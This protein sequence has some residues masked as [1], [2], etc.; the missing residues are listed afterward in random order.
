MKKVLI[1]VT[2]LTSGQY[3]IR[4]NLIEEYF[5]LIQEYFKSKIHHKYVGLV[6]E[7]PRQLCAYDQTVVRNMQGQC[8]A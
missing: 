5:F 1:P 7:I 2:K 4:A 8:L 3:K 6:L